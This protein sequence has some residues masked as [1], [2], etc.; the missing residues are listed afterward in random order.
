M[1]SINVL[2]ADDEPALRAQL[3]GMLETL[4]PMVCVREV[5]NGFD[6]LSSIERDKPDVAFLDI[7]MPAL[8]GLEVAAQVK[9][10]CQLVFVTAYDE[11]AID[12]FENAAVDYLLKPVQAERLQQTVQRLQNN[13]DRVAVPGV[14]WQ[15]LL[16]TLKL[17]RSQGYLNW[18]RV[19]VME[20]TLLLPVEE[21]VFFKAADKYTSVYTTGHEYL[22]SKNI[23]QLELEL[24]PASFW[25]IHRSVIVQVAEVKNCCK[26]LNGRYELKLKHRAEV[27]SVSRSYSHLFKNM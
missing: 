21:V 15:S 20:K 18:L 24:D 10:P 23:K 5:G 17:V 12:A 6:A 7:R 26:A 9:Q 22:I 13:L 2:I 16:D 3:R 4:W 11:Y 8:T 19:G 25:R 1:A 14:D 27:L